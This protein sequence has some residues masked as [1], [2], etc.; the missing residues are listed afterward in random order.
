MANHNADVHYSAQILLLKILE[1]QPNLISNCGQHGQGGIN[2]GQFI[3]SLYDQL[4]VLAQKNQ[5]VN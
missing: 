4:V 5:N 3:N 1:T 2:A